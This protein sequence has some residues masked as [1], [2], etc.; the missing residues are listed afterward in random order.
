M[1][2]DTQQQH[3]VAREAPVNIDPKRAALVTEWCKKVKQAKEHWEPVFKRMREDMQLARHGA[4]KDWIGSGYYVANIVQRHLSQRVASLY[5]KNPKSVAKPREQL[6]YQV[7][8]GNPNTLMMAQQSMALG[9]PDPQSMAI[10]QDVQQAHAR[11]KMIERVGKTLEVVYHYQLEQQIPSFKKMMKK[12]V[13]RSLTTGISYVTVDFVRAMERSVETQTQIVDLST[14]LATLQRLAA[15]QA[16]G[17][18]DES[19]AEAEKMRLMIQSLQQ[20][21]DVIVKEGLIFGFPRSTEII[22]DQ[23][24]V[25]PDGW[26]GTEWIAQ[27]FT[28]HPK[29]IQEIYDVDVGESY[30]G[31]TPDARKI[32]DESGQKESLALL[33]KIQDKESGMVFTVCDGYP[34]FLIEPHEPNAPIDGFFNIFALVFNDVESED[35]AFPEGDA[36]LVRS[37]QLEHNN[38]RQALREHRNRNRPAWVSPKGALE[39]ED[40][41][42]LRTNSVNALIELRGLQPG[43]DIKTVLQPKPSAAIDPNMYDTR[44]LTDDIL[45]TVGAQEANLG[46]AAGDKTAT[47]SSIAEGSRVSSV[48]SNVDDLDEFLTAITRAAGQILLRLMTP[49]T[50]KKI[51]GPGAVWPA[52]DNQTISDEIALSVR[53]GSSGRPNKGQELANL[54]RAT[55]LL[56]QTPG[57]SPTW[58]SKEVIKRMDDNIDIEEAII[59][60]LPSITAMNAAAGRPQPSTGDPNSDPAQQGDKGRDNAPQGEQPNQGGQPAYPPGG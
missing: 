3:V 57:V 15:D 23:K 38:T 33:W 10:L 11:A 28:L 36:R 41:N 48:S 45:W 26:I 43:Q 21:Q 5:A 20:N 44:Y 4:T 40:K 1:E 6:S 31:Y 56:V 51:A 42:N 19:D 25:D 12:A 58:L 16:D 30:T 27:E 22:P 60:G 53:S 35:E 55:P 46:P 24:T 29:K 50:A 52:L 8:D 59:E 18:S 47:E 7:W 34:D 49:E 9:V 39:D 37:M 17:E 54:E 14:K 32:I 13:R 2:E